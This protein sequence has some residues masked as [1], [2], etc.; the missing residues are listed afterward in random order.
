MVSWSALADR[1]NAAAAA[2]VVAS[3]AVLYFPSRFGIA[4]LGVLAGVGG[5]VVVLR[6]PLVRLAREVGNWFA[7][8]AV[9][10]V[11]Y[12]LFFSSGHFYS[13][14]FSPLWLLWTL[15]LAGAAA[16]ALTR[17][18]SPSRG[19]WFLGTFLGLAMLFGIQLGYTLQDRKSV[20]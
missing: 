5:L 3:S 2:L 1:A 15:V 6:R 8:A 4:H 7:G 18:S 13:R 16:I 10:C 14:Y 11:T 20:V 9:L 12:V 17:R 19:R